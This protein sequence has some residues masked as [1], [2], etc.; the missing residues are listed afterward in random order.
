M[1]S[2][3]VTSTYRYKRP[4]RKKK[5]TVLTGSA[6]VT[7]PPKRKAKA[8]TPASDPQ[9]SGSAIVRRVKAQ[10]DNRSAEQPSAIVTTRKS[11][12]L[13]GEPASP[14]APAPVDY[15]TTTAHF[16]AVL[17]NKLRK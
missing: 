2:A 10:K 3:I 12:K 17:A 8:H 5:P 6:I 13:R 11:S 14:D 7:P 15:E 1:T 16:R 4:P 9:A